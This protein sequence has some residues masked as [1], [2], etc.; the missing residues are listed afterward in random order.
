MVCP[1]PLTFQ[2][3]Q[4]YV[5]TKLVHVECVSLQRGGERLCGNEQVY[6]RVLPHHRQKVKVYF[7]NSFRKTRVCNKGFCPVVCL[8]DPDLST[9][10]CLCLTS[11]QKSLIRVLKCSTEGSSTSTTFKT[12]GRRIT[13]AEI[14]MVH[15]NSYCYLSFKIFYTCPHI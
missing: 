14:V 5:V 10:E 8:T 13:Y 3:T 15:E 9:T 6:G 7:Q 11:V 1:F 12:T 2:S 4:G